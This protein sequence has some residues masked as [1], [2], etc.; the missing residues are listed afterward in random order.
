MSRK[1]KLWNEKWNFFSRNICQ[2]Q[3]AS[4]AA[5]HVSL[6]IPPK[7]NRARQDKR[8]TL[9]G[10]KWRTLQEK[11]AS[12]PIGT[13][14]FFKFSTNC[15]RE[16]VPKR[17]SFD[18]LGWCNVTTNIYIILYLVC[19]NQ[20]N[21]F[22]GLFCSFCLE[23]SVGILGTYH[24]HF[25]PTYQISKEI[26]AL[27]TEYQL[28]LKT[29][30]AFVFTFGPFLIHFQFQ[31]MP[32]LKEMRMNQLNFLLWSNF[33]SSQVVEQ[34]IAVGCKSPTRNCQLLLL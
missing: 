28:I 6:A 32:L 9:K 8:F 7:E 20:S 31:W 21:A 15:G 34:K 24:S 17:E 5:P 29:Y 16:D 13:V 26:L 25:S 11:M 19:N 30:W 27:I 23:F 14:M 10:A 33:V 1:N 2:P 4:F 18:S 22:W 12:R 3:F